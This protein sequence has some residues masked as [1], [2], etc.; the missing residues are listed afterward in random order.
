MNYRFVR[1]LLVAV[2]LIAAIAAV[3]FYTYNLGVA[4]GVAETGRLVVP[5]GPNGMPI[6]A[7]WPRPWGYGFFPFFPL[8]FI[9][10]WV[11]VLRALFWRGHWRRSYGGWGGVPPAFEEWHRRMHEQQQPPSP[12]NL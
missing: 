8:L 7:F 11:F 6:V 12:T 4:H 5:G 10:F 1:A 3:G 2:L 9:L